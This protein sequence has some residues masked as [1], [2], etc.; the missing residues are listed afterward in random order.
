LSFA[1]NG[2]VGDGFGGRLWYEPTNYSVGSY[3]GFTVCDKEQDNQL[4]GWGSNSYGELGSSPTPGSDIPIE[5]PNMHHVKYYTTG[6]AMAAIKQDNT[7]WVWG[8]SDFNFTPTQVISDVKFVDA[9]VGFVS[10]IKNDGTVWSLGSNYG[11]FGDNTYLTY[12]TT[13]VQMLG[14]SDAVRV[15]CSYTQNYVLTDD[16]KVFT[17]GNSFYALGLQ[18]STI[19]NSSLPQQMAVLENIVDIKATT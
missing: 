10:F 13:P 11:G 12:S 18:D 3:S 17:C 16:G 14:I 15:A 2:I 7:G 9:A 8:F 19:T 1:Q 4:I 5:I 6:Y